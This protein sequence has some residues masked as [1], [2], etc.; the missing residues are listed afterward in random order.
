MVDHVVGLRRRRGDE[1]LTRVRACGD[2]SKLKDRK[3][4]KS[5][6]H[7]RVIDIGSKFMLL[8]YISFLEVEEFGVVYH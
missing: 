6:T 8:K 5:H 2:R 3:L 7:S 4:V 1:T